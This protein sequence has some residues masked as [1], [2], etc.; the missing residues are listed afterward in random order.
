LADLLDDID[1]L[2]IANRA[3]MLMAYREVERLKQD[4]VDV[5]GQWLGF[6]D[7]GEGQVLYEGII[8][9]CEVLSSSCIKK[10]SSVNLRRTPSGNFV[11]WQ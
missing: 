3:E 7:N 1:I 5:T 8:Y 11:D 9:Y 6:S 4:R 10:Y 2:R